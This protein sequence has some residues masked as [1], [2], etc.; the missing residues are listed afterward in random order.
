MGARYVSDHT[1]FIEEMKKN[2]PQVE[3][4][5]R[6]GRSIFWDKR[7]DLDEMRRFQEAEV[8]QPAYVYQNYVGPPRD[9]QPGDQV[10]E[11]T[12]ASNKF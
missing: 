3:E 2:D 9:Q 10:T 1:R 7:V 5:Q 4:G 8:Q 11:G 12:P 6:R